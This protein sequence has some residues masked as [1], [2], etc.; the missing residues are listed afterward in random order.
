MNYEIYIVGS[1]GIVGSIRISWG[2]MGFMR[3]MSLLTR[4]HFVV[5]YFGVMGFMRA[6]SLLL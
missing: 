1:I 5:G 4:Y 6:M 3:A 2:V